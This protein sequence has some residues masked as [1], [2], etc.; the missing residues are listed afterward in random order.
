[1]PLLLIREETFLPLDQS[2][3]YILGLFQKKNSRLL[4]FLEEMKKIWGEQKIQRG[5]FFYKTGK[6]RFAAKV[7]AADQS[8]AKKFVYQYRV[9]W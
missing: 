3:A 8:N 5:A 1:M 9:P 4:P 2:A 7:L 6:M